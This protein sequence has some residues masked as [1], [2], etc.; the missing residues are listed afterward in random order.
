MLSSSKALNFSLSCRND[1]AEDSSRIYQTP[2][3]D[4]KPSILSNFISR[5]SSTVDALQE[6]ICRVTEMRLAYVKDAPTTGKSKFELF[7]TSTICDYNYIYTPTF[8]STCLNSFL[9]WLIVALNRNICYLTIS[10]HDTISHKLFMLCLLIIKSVILGTD[11]PRR[12]IK[13]VP[14][15]QCHYYIVFLWTEPSQSQP[16]EQQRG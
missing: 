4:L 9:Q 8:L 15:N 16:T 1:K 13:T 7:L 10:C 5:C 6:A 11:E 12:V 14:V 3:N 2:T